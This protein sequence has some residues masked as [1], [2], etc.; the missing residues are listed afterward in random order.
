[1]TLAGKIVR[2][3]VS[4]ADEGAGAARCPDRCAHRLCVAASGLVWLDA[5]KHRTQALSGPLGI[6]AHCAAGR[7]AFCLVYTQRHA[8]RSAATRQHPNLGPKPKGPPKRNRWPSVTPVGPWVGG[9]EAKKELGSDLFFRYFVIVFLNSPH[10][11]TP[12]NAI[13]NKSRKSRFWTSGR[14][15]C[16][17]FSTRFFFQNVFCSVFEL[18]SL[19]NT[20][21]CDKTKNVEE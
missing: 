9:S 19:K 4:A 14:I 6:H 2:A 13:K 5:I 1:M 16:K 18:P 3:F 20:R 11:E 10:R 8:A 7:C 21:K 12:K 15:F 17:N